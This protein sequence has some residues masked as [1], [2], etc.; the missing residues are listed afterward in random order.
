[1]DT[2]VKS[3]WLSKSLR[4]QGDFGSQRTTFSLCTVFVLRQGQDSGFCYRYDAGSSEK[5]KVRW[6]RWSDRTGVGERDLL[7]ERQLL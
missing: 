5:A 6:G 7:Q 4:S 3:K 1:M 2:E